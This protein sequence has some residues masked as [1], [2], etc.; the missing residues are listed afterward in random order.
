MPPISSPSPQQ[1]A[2]VEVSAEIA[3]HRGGGQKTVLLLEDDPV[4]H[5]IM[6]EFL[7]EC[8]FTVVG[9]HDGADGLPEVIACDFDV[10]I[11]DVMMPVVPGDTFFRQVEQVRPHLCTRFVFMTGHCSHPKVQAFIRDVHATLLAK[12][13]QVDD[14]LRS[15][16]HV[17]D[18]TALDQ[19]A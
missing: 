4:F 14:L 2:V 17:Q 7:R 12:P 11:C 10:I 9:V 19:A 13:F 8:G 18:R 5:E 16:D 6:S 3:L 15:I 1:I